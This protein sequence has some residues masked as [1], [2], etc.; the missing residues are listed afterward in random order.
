MHATVLKYFREVADR[1]AIRKAAEALHVASSAVNRQILKLE[2]EIGVPLFERLPTGVRLTAAGEVLLRHVADTLDD[3][4]LVKSEIDE[5]RGLKTGL[6][7]VAALVGVMTEF[8]PSVVAE[9]QAIHPGVNFLLNSA[10]PEEIVDEVAAGRADIAVNFTDV[11]YGGFALIAQA[12][13]P[14]GA[15]VPQAHPLAKRR[16]ISL[17]EMAGHPLVLWSER[18]PLWPHLTTALKS[19]NVAASPRAMTNSLDMMKRLVRD[20]VGVGIFSRFGF[21]REIEDGHLVHVPF[22]EPF[23]ADR[24]IGVFTA[25]N[26]K[27]A[28]GATLFLDH[29]RRSV[30]AI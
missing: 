8:L 26:R 27:L 12:A 25:A 7:R 6:V 29:L 3:F 14:L 2:A 24:K 15:I 11:G 23:L 22:K 9:F 21:E 5:F 16:R 28:A 30:E 17:M 10:G 19:H 18:G 4:D 1:G 20:G 13:S